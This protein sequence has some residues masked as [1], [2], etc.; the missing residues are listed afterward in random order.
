MQSGVCSPFL[1]PV[2][3]GDFCGN[4]AAIYAA[5]PN[6]ACKLTMIPCQFLG[7]FSPR[8]RR[9]FD[10]FEFRRDLPAIFPLEDN[11]KSEGCFVASCLKRVKDPKKA[12]KL[13]RRRKR[14]I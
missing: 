11:K 3:T 7:D 2:Y 14:N 6:R 5:I 13:G 9:Y 12:I 10:L 1:G 8:N 4:F